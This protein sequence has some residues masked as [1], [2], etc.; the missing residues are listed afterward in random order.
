MLFYVDT[1]EFL[2]GFERIEFRRAVSGEVEGF[3]LR[4]FDGGIDPSKACGPF[5]RR[6][7]LQLPRLERRPGFELQV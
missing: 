4:T 1:D 7:E 2:K 3:A 5:F 6:L